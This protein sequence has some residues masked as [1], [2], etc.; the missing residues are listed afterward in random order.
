MADTTTAE[1]AAPVSAGL[2]F[3]VGSRPQKR[4]ANVQTIQPVTSGSFA[5][6]QLPASGHVRKIRLDFTLTGT[7][8]SAGAAVAGDAPFNLISGITLTDATGQPVQQ[9]ISGY[10]QYLVNKYFPSG[11]I[12]QNTASPFRNPHLSSD[13]R[14][15]VTATAIDVHFVLWIDVEQ[16]WNTGYGCIPNLDSNASLQLKVDYQPYTVVANGTTPSNVNLTMRVSQYYW[17]PVGKEVNGQALNDTP[18]GFGDYLEIR[19]ETQTVSAVAENLVTLTNRGGLIKG[20]ILVSRNA[21]AR[22]AWTTNSNVGTLLDNNPIDEGIT[23]PEFQDGVRHEYGFFG[24]DLTTNYAPVAA[25]TLPGLDQG[26]LVNNFAAKS[27]GR[28]SWLSTRTGS[29]L[30]MKV[31]PG[32]GATT[33]EIITLLMQVRD[34][35]AFYSPSS[36]TS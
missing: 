2:R 6:I 9:P 11:G 26:V 13:Y 31:T 7:F 28:D 5:P 36:L 10:E 21:G 27:G 15:S 4:F 34:A 29:L 18:V 19:R 8:A 30:Q 24:T 16:D 32:V 17:A 35:N 20:V 1:P 33:L 3:T 12:A 23:Y 22:T 25:G 14:Y